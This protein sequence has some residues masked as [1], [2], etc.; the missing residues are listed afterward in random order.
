M[1]ANILRP[2]GAII[3]SGTNLGAEHLPG[4]K[5][6][7]VPIWLQ[8]LFPGLIFIFVWFL[9]ESPRWNYT[10][11]KQDQVRASFLF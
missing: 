9:P 6:W 2:V 8:M 3:A 1:A 11:G 5:S 4:D 10:N 7:T